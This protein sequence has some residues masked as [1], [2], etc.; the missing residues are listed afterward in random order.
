VADPGQHH[1]TAFWLFP[2]CSDFSQ[3]FSVQPS[4][5]KGTDLFF[6]LSGTSLPPRFDTMI[7]FCFNFIN[8]PIAA[9]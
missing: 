7:N 9:D 5:E 2:K 6:I 4:E 3:T 1:N 8:E